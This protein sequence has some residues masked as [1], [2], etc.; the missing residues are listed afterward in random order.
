MLCPKDKETRLQRGKILQ[1]PNFSRMEPFTMPFHIFYLDN[2]HIFFCCN[3]Y[4]Y[5]K[6]VLKQTQKSR[7]VWCVHEYCLFCV[8]KGAL[9]SSLSG[10]IIVCCASTMTCLHAVQRG[11][12]FLT[13]SPPH[14]SGLI[15]LLKGCLLS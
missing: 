8:L 11:L 12:C 2:V 6:I 4:Y 5:T 13:L 1:T 3:T 9:L 10:F 15:R 7:D 14:K